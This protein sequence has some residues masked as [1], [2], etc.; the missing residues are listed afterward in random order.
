MAEAKLA[1]PP[2]L[3]AHKTNKAQP[4]AHKPTT[5]WHVARTATLCQKERNNTNKVL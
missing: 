4:V 5:K 2:K 1:S 3:V